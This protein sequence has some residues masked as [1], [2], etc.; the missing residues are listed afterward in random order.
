MR[1][2]RVRNSEYNSKFGAPTESELKAVLL[3][4]LG[5]IVP[6]SQSLEIE[7]NRANMNPSLRSAVRRVLRPAAR[8]ACQAQRRR[9]GSERERCV[10]EVRRM[11]R[12]HLRARDAAAAAKDNLAAFSG[13]M[14][15][16]LIAAAI[17]VLKP[18]EK[19]SLEI[20]MESNARSREGSGAD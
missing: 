3:Y 1:L 20:W 14:C 12:D 10:E 6:Q 5:E 8:R 11:T 4:M 7:S 19:S 2:I 18:R 17:H 13:I 15:G 9:R 16:V